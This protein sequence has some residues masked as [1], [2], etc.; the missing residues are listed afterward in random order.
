M[1]V[2]GLMENCYVGVIGPSASGR[3]VPVLLY[4]K[5]AQWLNVGC[6]GHRCGKSYVPTL[7]VQLKSSST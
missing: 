6:T 3:A 2:Y 7:Q 5:P 1:K 4:L